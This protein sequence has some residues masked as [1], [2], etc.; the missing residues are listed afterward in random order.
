MTDQ[1]DWQKDQR[2]NGLIRYRNTKVDQRQSKIH[3]I[4]ADL[5]RTCDDERTGHSR[6]PAAPEKKRQGA[7]AARHGG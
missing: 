5:I 2:P 7:P 4:A 6:A 3:R 1:H